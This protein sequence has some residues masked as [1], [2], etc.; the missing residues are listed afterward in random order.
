MPEPLAAVEE[1]PAAE[2]TT[3]ETATA[4][5]RGSFRDAAAS[6]GLVE[7][8]LSLAG[9]SVRL[10]YA[11]TAMAN[12]QMD[13]FEHAA[14]DDAG[15]PALRIHIWDSRST[16]V[17]PP[18][19]PPTRGGE[20]RGALYYFEDGGVRGAYQP[21]TST[22]SV[23]DALEGEAWY[24]TQDAGELPYWDRAEPIRQ[25]LHWWLDSRGM[26]RLHAGA[27]GNANGGVIVVGRSGSGKSTTALSSLG[28]GMFYGG[29][30]CIAVAVDP[31]P[32]VYTLYNSGKLHPADLERFPYLRDAVSNPNVLDYEKAIFYVHGQFPDRVVDGFPLRAVLLPTI[33]GG[34]TRLVPVSSAAALVALA[35]STILQL[36]PIEPRAFS[37]MARLVELVPSFRLELG[38]DIGEIP[39]TIAAFLDSSA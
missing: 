5:L 10:S 13:A 1:L 29:D 9:E 15:E 39:T 33:T 11:G 17:E 7:R 12:V 23:F 30:D 16:G 8:S 21:G 2:S 27:V 25:L 36:P 4:A 28:A 3:L 14:R 26:Q 20:V 32:Y 19:V 37:A 6:A 24:W 34:A 18:P 38:P 31:E 35:P 22:F